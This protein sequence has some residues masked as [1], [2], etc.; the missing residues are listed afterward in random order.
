MPGSAALRIAR[1]ETV[2]FLR[3]PVAV[4]FSLA[5]PLILLVFV[6][7]VIGREMVD[8]GVRGIDAFMPTMIGVTA[9]NVGVMGFAIHVAEERSRGVLRRMRLAPI[10]DI[11]YFVAQM[12]TAGAMLLVAIVLLA[13]VTFAF[14]GSPPA[15]DWSVLNLIPLLGASFVAMYVMFSLGLLVGGLRMPVRSIQVV[16][17]SIFFVMFFS[18]GAAI[19]REGFPGW[20]QALSEVNP[21]SHLND[22]LLAAY[23]GRSAGEALVVA[24]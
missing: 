16:G 13:A 20:L 18:S 7:S 23:L 14:Y 5:F 3:E 4:F 10:R 11:D 17:A 24:G 19:P 6:G 2:L 12:I 22:F 15:S 1:S 8:P 9:A 21:L